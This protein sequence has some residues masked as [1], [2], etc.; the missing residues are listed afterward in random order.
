MISQKFAQF[1]KSPEAFKEIFKFSQVFEKSFKGFTDLPFTETLLQDLT[2]KIRTL[3]GKIRETQKKKPSFK[4]EKYRK[5]TN[6]EKKQLCSSIKKLNPVHL[7]GVL[8]IVKKNKGFKGGE[9]E[10]DLE[11]LPNK[12][13]RELEKYIKQ[14]LLAKNLKNKSTPPVAIPS[15]TETK[16]PT[17]NSLSSV[18]SSFTSESEDELPG[19]ILNCDI[20]DDDFPRLI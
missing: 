1:S 20:W 2:E 17:S 14:C 5:M 12:V 9:L 7:N 13:L 4:V 8:K 15:N 16:N 11:K 6:F 3:Q 10:F 18:S 19:P